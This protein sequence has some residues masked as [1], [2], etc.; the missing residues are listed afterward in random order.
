VMNPEVYWVPEL[1]GF[2][3]AIMPRPRGHE[4]L[5]EEV[6]GWSLLGLNHVI[7]LLEPHEVR[8]LG[9]LD[10][11]ALCAAHALTFTSFPVPDR[12]VPASL[13]RASEL[14]LGAAAGLTSGEAIAIHCRAGIG[15]SALLAGCILINL[16]VPEAEVFPRISRG[17]GIQVP[18]TPAQIQWLASYAREGR[19]VLPANRG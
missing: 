4:W 8:E 16:G 7:S 10:E 9:L 1:E 11:A 15:R 5:A 6:R 3:L 13:H 17:R 12:G 19:K 14:I 2:R 18:D